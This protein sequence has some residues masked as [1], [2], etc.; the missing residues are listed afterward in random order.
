[1]SQL[2]HVEVSNLL[3]QPLKPL[4]FS[5]IEPEKPQ[6]CLTAFN[7]FFRN[8]RQNLLDGIKASGG[9]K[10]ANSKLVFVHMARIIS[11]KWKATT[12]YER[13]YYKLLENEEKQRYEG[14]MKAWHHQVEQ[15]KLEQA[16]L[17]AFSGSID[18]PESLDSIFDEE[19]VDV[20]CSM[21]SS[22]QVVVQSQQS[23][24]PECV[25]VSDTESESVTASDTESVVEIGRKQQMEQVYGEMPLTLL[26][27]IGDDAPW[28]F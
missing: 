1:M 25:M 9:M 14:E 15:Q 4:A 6:R 11:A 17:V 13:I 8:E 28:P 12:E 5:F 7:L 2:D 18:L 26:G 16:A 21:T 20:S 24:Q 10:Q 3:N 27:D 23:V 19:I 22:E